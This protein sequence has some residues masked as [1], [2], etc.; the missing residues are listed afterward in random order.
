MFG[1]TWLDP[2]ALIADLNG[3]ALF[4]ILAIVFLEMGVLVFFF[5]PGDSL[6]FVAGLAVAHGDIKLGGGSV[7]IWVLCVL[8]PLAAFLGDLTGF[9]VGKN[10]GKSL[11][12]RPNSRF[13]SQKNVESTHAFFE[14]HGAGAVI[15]SH[16]VVVM[17]TFVPVAAGIG[18]MDIRK[19]VRNSAI[20]AIAWGAGL[21]LLGAFLGGF[22][23]VSEHIDLWAIGF[24]VVSAIP[25][26]IEG[27]KAR[28]EAR[29]EA[30]ELKA[31]D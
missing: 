19:F 27:L 31:N 13:F 28:R 8:V 16:F 3:F 1:I 21:T 14:K 20:G 26:V 22:K 11:F 15:L 5:L 7:P 24:L 10:W 12:N 25:V 18:D 9:W 30:Q 6:L 2:H 17:R 29:T 4:A 23:I